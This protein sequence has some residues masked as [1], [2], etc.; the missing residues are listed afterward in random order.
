MGAGEICRSVEF[1]ARLA[2]GTARA[3]IRVAAGVTSGIAGAGIS[4]T[5]R[6]LAGEEVNKETIDKALVNG[7]VFGALGGLVGHGSSNV[8]KIYDTD[9]MKKTAKIGIAAAYAKTAD[10]MSNDDDEFKSNVRVAGRL[11]KS[12]PPIFK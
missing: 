2:T 8:T 7:Y 10:K 6:F 1:G 9:A 4:E 12:V 3:G 5:G 11:M